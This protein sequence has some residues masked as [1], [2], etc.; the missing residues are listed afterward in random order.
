VNVLVI[1]AGS[2]SVKVSLFDS[3]KL[4]DYLP[5]WK[6]AENTADTPGAEVLAKLLKQTPSLDAVEAVGHRIVHGGN[7]Y[8][9]SVVIDDKV[10]ANLKQCIELAPDHMPDNLEGITTA[11]KLIPKAQHI[12]VFDTAFHQTMPESAKVLPGPYS[13]YEEHGIKR[14]GFH[15]I[16]HKYCSLRAAEILH[17]SGHA[18]QKMIVC[19]LGAG[20][21]LCAVKDGKS[22]MNTMSYTPL[23]GLIMQTRSGAIDIGAAI[24]LLRKNVYDVNGLD[25]VLNE[26]SGLKGISG[27]SGDM[28]ELLQAAQS[29]NTRAQLALDMFVNSVADNIAALIPR[30]GGIDAL[31]FTAGIGENSPGIRLLV[32]KQLEFI[33]V[34]LDEKQNASAAED[35]L[36]SASGSSIQC[37]VIHTREDLLIARECMELL[38]A[39]K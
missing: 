12:A 10:V 34:R 24:H 25:K 19:H 33:D 26:E 16:S 30:L 36:I 18:A 20:A 22:V 23:D 1:N 15:G 29:K 39:A 35:K 5:V 21:S 28:Q 4:E 17:A 37:L 9:D 27:L 14:F 3:D 13:W 7:F 2:S 8:S 32:C 31:I 6:A 38:C 11:R